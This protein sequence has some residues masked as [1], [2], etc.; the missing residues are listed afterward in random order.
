MRAIKVYAPGW[1]IRLLLIQKA[2]HTFYSANQFQIAYTAVDGNVC[3][4]NLGLYSMHTC[5]YVYGIKVSLISSDTAIV[6]E[7]IPNDGGVLHRNVK[8]L[9]S[10]NYHAFGSRLFNMYRSIRI[11]ERYLSLQNLGSLKPKIP[12]KGHAS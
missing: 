12:T 11:N 8:W 6:Y 3:H 1:S 9:W 2:V 10:D 5:K 4:A 7:V